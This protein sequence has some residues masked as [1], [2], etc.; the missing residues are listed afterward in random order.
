VSGVQL[1]TSDA[2]EG[3]N[4]AIAAVLQGA[5]ATASPRTS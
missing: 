3:L 5:K 4:G 2:H 1:V